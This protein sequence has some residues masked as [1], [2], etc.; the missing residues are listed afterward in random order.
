MA[1]A[2]I[3]LLGQ[4]FTTTSDA[5]GRFGLKIPVG[6]FSYLT[7]QADEYV[8]EQERL[9]GSVVAERP[10]NVEIKMRRISDRLSGAL[11]LAN[12]QGYHVLAGTRDFLGG[13]FY[14][15]ASGDTVKFF[16]NNAFQRGLRDLGDLGD[17][18]LDSVPISEKGTTRFG[19]EAIEGHTYVSLAKAGEEGSFVVFRVKDVV[20]GRS[21]TIQFHYRGSADNQSE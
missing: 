19:V 7:V 8:P 13:D 1:G 18:D 14:V 17:V 3:E 10:L 16:A 11:R 2:T 5:Q 4:G 9:R 21:V 15:S 12:E 6:R 20:P